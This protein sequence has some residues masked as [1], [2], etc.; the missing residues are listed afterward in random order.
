MSQSVSFCQHIS[1]RPMKT[2][3]VLV[4]SCSLALL[5][6]ACGKKTI[7]ITDGHSPSKP[8]QDQSVYYPKGQPSGE[9]A[10]PYTV[11]GKTYYPLK[12]AH[13][14]V[15]EG[16]ASWYGSDFHGKKTSNGEK[17][18]MYGM[19]AAHKLL[20]FNTRVRVT[21]L[22]NGK[23]IIVR[24]NDR[25]P[26]V[27]DRV[28]DLTH[29][30]AKAIDMLGPG[31]ARVRIEAIGTT[32]TADTGIHKG[33]FFVQIGAFSSQANAQKLVDRMRSAGYQSRYVYAKNVGM[34]RVQIGPI[35]SPAEAERVQWRLKPE[36]QGA[37]IVVE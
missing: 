9:R 31:T 13:G 4:L 2:I 26:F 23:S 20:P 27:G 37:S 15:E 35:A 28:I 25:G 6:S 12:S 5:A 7:S 24:I 21:N 32:P 33:P 17:Y 3:M 16:V 29:S 30:G 10:K 22:S 18:D 36:F 14:F 1:R 8:P 34:W 11:L 19:T